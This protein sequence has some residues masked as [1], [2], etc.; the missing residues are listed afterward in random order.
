MS[1]LGESLE[2]SS[3]HD[4]TDAGTFRLLQNKQ[5]L[6]KQHHLKKHIKNLEGE[7]QKKEDTIDKLR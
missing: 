6:L 3:K 1:S 7:V 5:E 2:G 4:P